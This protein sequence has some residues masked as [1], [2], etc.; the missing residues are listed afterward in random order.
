V[1][2]TVPPSEAE[3]AVAA[4]IRT[5]MSR[6]ILMEET[7]RLEKALESLVPIYREVILLHKYEHQLQEEQRVRLI[8][9]PFDSGQGLDRAAALNRLRAGIDN[10]AFSSS[11]RLPA[12][13]E[14]HDR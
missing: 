14:R 3:E 6:L 11:G 5:E 12:R 13:D 9:E 8:I 4:E 1:K 7:T 2:K 10:M